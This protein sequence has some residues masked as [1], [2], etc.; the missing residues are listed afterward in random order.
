VV[1]KNGDSHRKEKCTISFSVYTIR[2]NLVLYKNK[3][4]LNSLQGTVKFVLV[5]THLI[6]NKCKCM[7][8]CSRSSLQGTVK[9]ALVFT[10]LI[11]NKCKCMLWCS[12]SSLQ[13]RVI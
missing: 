5:F 4:S 12:R 6:T 2:Y 8:W 13:D 1:Y 7:L 11:T 9:F 3:R 10:H